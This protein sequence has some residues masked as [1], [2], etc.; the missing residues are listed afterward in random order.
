M[1]EYNPRQYWSD[2]LQKEGALYVSTRNSKTVND[3]QWSVFRDAL[4]QSIG[5]TSP[6][7]IIDFGCGVGRFAETALTKAET[8]TGVDINDGAFAHAPAV[9]G[10]SFVGLPD[11]RIPFDDGHFDS[12]MTLTVLQHIVDPAQFSNWASELGRVVKSGGYFY[13][14]DDADTRPK[15]AFHM[16][17]RGPQVICEALGAEID[18]DFG[19]ISAERPNSH[20]LFR[21]RKA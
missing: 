3:H 19:I 12:G 18:E 13:I 2:R 10:A 17:I 4:L 15:M 8:Y 14:I 7:N 21:A 9:E 20:Y 11:D 5:D 16:K 6:G 1:S